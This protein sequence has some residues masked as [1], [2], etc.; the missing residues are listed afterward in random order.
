LRFIDPGDAESFQGF[1]RFG[2]IVLEPAEDDE[3]V[4]RRLDL[5]AEDLE[6][7]P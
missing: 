4:S 3:A 5:V 6:L 2:G 1:Y 7:R